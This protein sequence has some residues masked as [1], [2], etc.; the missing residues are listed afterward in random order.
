MQDIPYKT[1]LLA[2]R[3]DIGDKGIRAFGI[4]WFLILIGYVA[5]AIGVAF[6]QN[7]WYVV[8]MAMTSIS[9]IVCILDVPAA[10]FGVIINVVLLILLII[11]PNIGWF[12]GRINF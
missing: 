4:V 8:T 10:K 9:L 3:W 12:E 2:G 11:G 5:G 6:N 7:W 1:T